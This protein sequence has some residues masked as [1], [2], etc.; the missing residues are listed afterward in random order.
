MGQVQ[1]KGGIAQTAPDQA[2]GAASTRASPEQPP[3]SAKYL[4]PCG[5][6]QTYQDS[7]L[8]AQWSAAVAARDS[9]DWA[10]KTYH[11][12][13][14]GAAAIGLSLFL[15]GAAAVLALLAYRSTKRTE[16]AQTRAYIFPE[17]IN[18]SD[19]VLQQ[20][21]KGIFTSPGI[22]VAL[23]NSGNSPAHDIKNCCRVE[24]RENADDLG[25][26]IMDGLPKSNLPP[27]G[28]MTFVRYLSDE[29]NAYCLTPVGANLIRE[30]R[31]FMFAYGRIEYRDIYQAQRFTN[32]R[33]EYSGVWPPPPD[34]RMRFSAAGNESN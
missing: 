4:N 23:K 34:A 26:A 11:V 17:Y 3:K 14:A 28:T 9:A 18:I 1:S 22:A 27:D 31:A 20:G 5:A 30:N 10:A 7:E 33:L 25:N 16:E 32:F 2:Q 12:E 8:C 6:G 29:E 13:V 24:L 21:S 15:S 19:G